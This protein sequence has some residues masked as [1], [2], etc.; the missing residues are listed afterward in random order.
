[1]LSVLGET[2]GWEVF[3]EPGTD[4]IISTTFQGEEPSEALRRL[5]GGLNF[6]L[7][8]QAS[9]PARLFVYQG[10]VGN[11]TLVVPHA[12]P[13]PGDTKAPRGIP[14]ELVVSLKPGHKRDI[15]AIARGLG[16]KVIGRD[17]AL[18]LYRL[19]FS[20]EAAAESARTALAADEDVGSVDSN[21]NIQRP[22]QLDPL[23]LS[24]APPI[25]IRASSAGSAD[26]VVVAVIDTAV[27]A[28]NPRI[29]DFL[30]APLSVADT[31]GG[32]T[33]GLSHGTAMAETILR[34]VSLTSQEVDGSRVRLLPI[35]VYG[36][37]ETTTLFELARALQL[38][39]QSGA[40]ILNMSLGSEG[41]APFLKREIQ[42]IA[43]LDIV[44][45]A[46]AGNRPVTTPVYP[47]A[48]PEVTAVTAGDS[49]GH[50][51]PYANRG[52]F[53]DVIAPGANVVY[54]GGSAYL[55]TGTSFAT[56]WF[57]G[58]AAGGATQ[59]GLTPASAAAQLRQ[60]L[61]F[62]PSAKP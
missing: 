3:V 34:G 59:T 40:R 33:D 25:Q 55:G 24:S 6:A 11:A 36:S 52:A 30:L 38:A 31:P 29:K 46:A 41:E 62:P 47:A 20:D 22:G 44:M 50:I 18:G 16:A 14:D 45:V 10:A 17:D 9:G 23:R 49:Q 28:S 12:G 57:S 1:V 39:V 54:S 35:D 60:K 7:L 51:A 21:F 27:D 8:P 5:V 43:A 2:T 15:D 42:A 53:V 4:P 19:R 26:Q 37:S 61:A 13:G 48:E 58:M 56:A 32:A